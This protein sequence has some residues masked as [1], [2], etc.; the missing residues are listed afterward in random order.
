MYN[1]LNTFARWLY[2]KTMPPALLG[3]QWTGTHYVDNYKRTRNPTPN[4]LLAELKGTA[5]TCISMNAS[6]CA[7]Y[8]PQLYVTTGRGEAQPKCATRSLGWREVQRIKSLPH[9]SPRIK[10]SAQIREVTEH[11]LLTLLQHV[12][13]IHNSFD[14]FELTQVYLEVHGKAFW[15]VHK[16]LL[17]VPDEIWILPTQ[18]VTPKRQ[19]GSGKLDRLLRISRRQRSEQLRG[20]RRDLLSLS[21]SARSVSGR[22]V[23]A[24]GLLRAG[25]A[26]QRIRGHQK[27]S[28]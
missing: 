20:R 13:P 28:L 17:G 2:R 25:G 3:R 10:A 14:L 18:N 5:W 23:A 19:P 27:C 9:V 7:S 21:R 16:N 1:L 4:E 8:P 11:P 24:A 26:H 15:Y 12:N 6:V 22:V